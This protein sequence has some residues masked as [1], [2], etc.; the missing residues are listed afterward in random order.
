MSVAEVQQD[1]GLPLAVREL[2][3]R[4]GAN[5]GADIREVQLTQTGRMKT[6]LNATVWLPFTANQKIS[7]HACAFD[8]LAHAGPLGVISARDALAA[9]E[10]SLDVTALGFIPVAR[11]EH[12]P[13]LVRGELMRYLAEL[14]LAPDA[15][16][17]N[18]ELRWREVSP[19]RLA[20]SA[21][22][23]DT[24]GEVHLSLDGDGRVAVAFAAEVA[25]EIE[26]KETI[27]WQGQMTGW[28][29]S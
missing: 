7:T 24:A 8:W 9:G 14:P 27:Y 2:A 28:K 5:P 3:V 12:S 1:A 10:G 18:R 6:D 15:I 16:L 11:A 29:A 4:L 19:G 26:G 23:G 22:S 20:V 13:A 17:H 25:W 21:G